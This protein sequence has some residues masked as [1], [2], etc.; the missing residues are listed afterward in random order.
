[1]SLCT[2]WLAQFRDGEHRLEPQE[3]KQHETHYVCVD[4]GEIILQYVD[5]QGG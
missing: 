1:M 2:S 3:F 5:G 4:C